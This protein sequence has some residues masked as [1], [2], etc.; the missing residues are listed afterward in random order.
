VVIKVLFPVLVLC[1]IA[2]VAV[3]LAIHFR[4]KKHLRGEAAATAETVEA[5]PREQSEGLQTEETK[6]NGST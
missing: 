1:T 2:V 4:V 3:V 6:K 5:S